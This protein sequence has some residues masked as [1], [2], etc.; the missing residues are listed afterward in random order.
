VE[1]VVPE[2]LLD[3]VYRIAVP[4][5]QSAAALQPKEIIRE[6]PTR[7]LQ[8]AEQLQLIMIASSYSLVSIFEAGSIL[9]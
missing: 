9:V 1:D 5:S 7:L 8:S 6:F 4:E 2:S 3:A